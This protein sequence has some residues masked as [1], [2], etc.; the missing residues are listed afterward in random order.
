MNVL[1]KQGFGCDL[2]I[3][4]KVLTTLRKSIMVL[5]CLQKMVKKLPPFGILYLRGACIMLAFGVF[6]SGAL[7]FC[8]H[9]FKLCLK[10]MDIL[11]LNITNYWVMKHVG[12]LV[13]KN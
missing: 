13:K 8:E 5:E 7:F 2:S 3:A 9:T 6:L 11:L 12:K 10:K 1:W 4:Q